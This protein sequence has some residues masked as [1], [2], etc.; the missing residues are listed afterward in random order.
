MPKPRLYRTDAIVLR[1]WDFG[2]ADRLVVLLTAALGKIRAVAKG[3]R[4]SASR[5][6]GHLMPFA[7]TEVLLARG[8]DLDV[9]SQAQVWES[10]GGI[11]EDLAKTAYAYLM[12]ELCDRLVEEPSEGQ[13]VFRLLLSALRRLESDANPRLV[14]SQF[15]LHVLTE[16]GY[17]AELYRCVKCFSGLTPLGL[18]FSSQLGGLVCCDC[19]RTEGSADGLPALVVELMRELQTCGLAEQGRPTYSNE[20]VGQLLARLEAH[21]EHLLGAPLRSARVIR[22]LDLANQVVV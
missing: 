13:A 8:R 11:R 20:V 1:S 19:L 15:T 5:R 17:R 4:R 3:V 10:F 22:R 9:I 21:V 6:A 16:A 7:R 12:A 14:A 2:E 18:G